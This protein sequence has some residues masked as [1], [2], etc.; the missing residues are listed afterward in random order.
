[1]EK[2]I[3]RIA[4]Y[5]VEREYE[6]VFVSF[7]ESQGDEKAINRI[8]ERLE[9]REKVQ[10][11]FYHNKIKEVLQLFSEAQ[12][13]IGTRFH[14]I[15]LGWLNK[16]KVLPIVYDEKTKNVLDD[17]N[18]NNYL[19]LEEMESCDLED[20]L[21]RIEELRDEVVDVLK[22]EAYMQF[23]ALDKLLGKQEGNAWKIH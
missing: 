7:C 5:Y 19:N 21:E 13:V 12:I 20:K 6:V 14:S 1:M 17:L 9:E 23:W 15:I 10:V 11:L 8:I 4:E 18:Y 2:I 3:Q 22:N 16:K